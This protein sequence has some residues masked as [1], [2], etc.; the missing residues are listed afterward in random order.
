M[1][2]AVEKDTRLRDSFIVALAV[3]ILV[4]VLPGIAIG[5]LF[6]QPLVS[7]GMLFVAL[8]LWVWHDVY[9]TM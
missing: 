7:I 8:F 4:V 5:F 3:I 1:K 6:V 9:E 2:P